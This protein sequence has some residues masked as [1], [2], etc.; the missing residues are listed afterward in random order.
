MN[1]DSL[2]GALAQSGMTRSS[3]NRM[4]NSLG[5]GGMLDSLAGM[6]GGG[7]SAQ[8]APASGGALSGTLGNILKEAG[9]AVGGNQNLALGG[10]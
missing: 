1:I 5:G 9:R 3:V 8:R 7:T 10:L 4:T 6:L 2:L